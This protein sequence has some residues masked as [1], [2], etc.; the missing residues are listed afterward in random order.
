MTKRAKNEGGKKAA[1]GQLCQHLPGMVRE[2]LYDTVIGAGLACVA[3]VLESNGRRRVAS[4][5]RIWLI[6]R[7][8][9]RDMWRDSLVLGGRRVAVQPPRARSVAGCELRL[10]SWREWSACD[11]LGQRA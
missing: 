2:A 3:E 7:S 6:V 11:P 4:A 10:P 9:V 5:M 1:P 8:S